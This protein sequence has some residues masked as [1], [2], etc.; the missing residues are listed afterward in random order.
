MFLK[1][2]KT[3]RKTPV[4]EFL[5]NKA[6]GLSHVTLSKNVIWHRCFP[7]NFAK[8]SKHLSYKTHPGVCFLLSQTLETP[9]SSHLKD[10]SR[11]KIL[12]RLTWVYAQ[13]ENDC[14]ISEKLM[15]LVKKMCNFLPCSQI[16]IWRYHTCDMIFRDTLRIV[17]VTSGV[18]VEVPWVLAH[19]P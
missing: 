16:W 2:G 3:H 4:S 18:T 13:F 10:P 8:F 7:A 1:F 15:K 5:F 11:Q 6:A 14:T 17:L 9:F 12:P 19:V